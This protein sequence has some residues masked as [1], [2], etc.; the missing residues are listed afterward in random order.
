MSDTLPG[1][2][3]TD[4]TVPLGSLAGSAPA[5]QRDSR[6]KTYRSRLRPDGTKMS[7]AEI[8]AQ[9]EAEEEV[10][11]EEK[12]E[13]EAERARQEERN[14][15]RLRKAEEAK[16]KAASGKKLNRAPTLRAAATAKILS[17]PKK[18]AE[19]GMTMD[20]AQ[21]AR[22]VRSEVTS[23][24][25][26]QEVAPQR[27]QLR[28]SDS[29]SSEKSG[30]DES[31]DRRPRLMRSQSGLSASSRRSA[32]SYDDS[33][34]DDSGDDKTS[35]T[36][37][38]MD[39]EVLPLHL[40]KMPAV[41]TGPMESAEEF[42]AR[43]LAG[44]G[45]KKSESSEDD[46]DSGSEESSEETTSSDDARQMSRRGPDVLDWPAPGFQ[47]I[48]MEV[49][50]KLLRGFAGGMAVFYGIVIASVVHSIMLQETNFA[51]IK[52]QIAA[53]FEGEI[54]E[55]IPVVIESARHQLRQARGYIDFTKDLDVVEFTNLF[56]SKDTLVSLVWIDGGNGRVRTVNGADR[57]RRVR[58]DWVAEGGTPQGIFSNYVS[59]WQWGQEWK[60]WSN[61]DGFR[62]PTPVYTFYENTQLFGPVQ[63]SIEFDVTSIQKE[64][65]EVLDQFDMNV[66]DFPISVHI[67][68]ANYV[69]ASAGA[70][71]LALG[72]TTIPSECTWNEDQEY[73]RVCV[74]S[75]GHWFGTTFLFVMQ[76]LMCVLLLV[77]LVL[78]FYL[79]RTRERWISYARNLP[80]RSEEERQQAL[81]KLTQL[82]KLKQRLGRTA[83]DGAAAMGASTT[84][85]A[86]RVSD[87][88]DA[89]VDE[90][91]LD[92]SRSFK[93]M[94]QSN[95]TMAATGGRRSSLE[96]T[97]SGLSD[98]LRQLT[99]T[100]VSEAFVFA[101]VLVTFQGR[102]QASEYINMPQTSGPADEG[103]VRQRL[104]SVFGKV[105]T[106]LFGEAIDANVSAEFEAEEQAR[107]QAQRLQ[108]ESQFGAFGG[109]KEFKRTGTM[110]GTAM[111]S[112][113]GSNTMST[114][115]S[116]GK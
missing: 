58:I 12:A 70:A 44:L 4:E 93:M 31:S 97:S 2:G 116:S 96:A 57:L 85:F 15:E 98:R 75:A 51:L 30:G 78:I 103:P 1:L 55:K 66:E 107:Q 3:T 9:E 25:S 17:R 77:P 83:E 87:D 13:E 22:L 49:V 62:G 27:P 113:R 28:R 92:L 84:S 89:E 29:M 91:R 47:M 54:Y 60:W 52:R 111:S 65:F 41:N 21:I 48:R 34:S 5:P 72:S 7:L 11:A 73:V 94:L 71:P 114:S 32:S 112:S 24:D 63:V 36:S 108:Q 14:K 69:V 82:K 76:V 86:S 16:A 6:P 43:T 40:R 102:V 35:A 64:L 80:M 18:L 99:I 42:R 67:Y 105:K 23:P 19:R 109:P 100:S 46:D 20:P 61:V 38:D 50:K 79:W 59:G 33:G 26:T 101:V 81:D 88:M 37:G 110:L 56:Q 106:A 115:R 53:R 39:D 90:N 68:T 8:R 95:S 10:E 45:D 104:N 74:E